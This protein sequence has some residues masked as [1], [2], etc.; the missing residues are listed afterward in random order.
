MTWV[1]KYIRIQT[2]ETPS[3][4]SW[5]TGSMNKLCMHFKKFCKKLNLTFHFIFHEML[6]PPQTL[7]TY[8]HTCI[9][10]V[11]RLCSAMVSQECRY[12]RI[13]KDTEGYR[14]IQWIQQETEVSQTLYHAGI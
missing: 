7:T 11:L 14:R 1:Q 3:K 13:Q 4:A 9:A 12:S 6:K 5:G 10:A 2:Y 8:I